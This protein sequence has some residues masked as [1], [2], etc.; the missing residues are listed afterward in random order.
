MESRKIAVVC[1]GKEISYGLNLFH[2]FQ[3]KSEKE[4]FISNLIDDISIEMYS[5][6]AFSH[7]N[8]CRNTIRIYVGK[9]QDIDSSY[10]GIFG[11]F[12]MFIYKSEMNY[13][14]KADD[15]QLADYEE[16]IYYANERR[17]EYFYLEKKYIDRVNALNPKWITGI[18]KK[19]HTKGRDYNKSVTAQQQYDC[20]AYVMYLDVLKTEY[21]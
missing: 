5:V 18:F 15:K 17:K 6:A 16:F 8:A 9:A 20:L 2:L 3:Y 10:A 11:K 13:V 12:G 1:D 7:V 19:S 4:K 21:L 14:L